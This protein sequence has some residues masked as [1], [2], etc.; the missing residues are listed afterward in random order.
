RCASTPT[1]SGRPSR[2]LTATTEGSLRTM[3]RPRTYTTVLA[4][5][6]STAMSRPMIEERTFSDIAARP[7]LAASGSRGQPTNERSR[8]IGRGFAPRSG[9]QPTRRNRNATISARGVV[10]HPTPTPGSGVVH[11]RSPGLSNARFWGLGLS[12][13]RDPE[14]DLAGG[15]L[16]A[17]GGVHQVLGGDGGEVAPDGAGLGVV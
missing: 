3:P 9:C 5:P 10:S 2:T 6:R 15:R 7:P 4:V 1:A 12:E 8:R 16:V 17:V 13:V 14:R 11:P